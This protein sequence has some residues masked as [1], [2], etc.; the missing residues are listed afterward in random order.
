MKMSLPTP[1]IGANMSPKQLEA[2]EAPLIAL[3]NSAG[4]DL[5][6]LMY[7]FFSFLHRRT[8]FYLVPNDADIKEGKS[9]MGFLEGEAEKLLLAAFRQFPLRRMPRQQQQHVTDKPAQEDEP[10]PFLGKKQVPPPALKDKEKDT[11]TSVAPDKKFATKKAEDET[12]LYTEEGLQVPVGNG[13]STKRFKWTQTIDECTVL[14]G[15]PEGIRAKELDVSIKASSI[16]A[17]TKSKNADGEV[18]V[19]VEGALVEKVKPDECTWSLEGG[20]LLLILYKVKKTF[21]A[22]IIEG[23]EKIDTSQV[24]SR[25]HISE[26]DEATQGQLR[27]IMFDQKQQEK[28]LPSSDE[29]IG[30]RTIPPMPPGVEYIDSEKLNEADKQRQKQKL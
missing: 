8:D 13:G 19:F 3:A 4:G 23:D 2:M 29:L 9:K 12:I 30:K 16:H 7:G 11:A 5:R 21:W 25:R 24:D 17:K 22:T 20:V 28:G 18:T 15:L 26:Y 10:V 1:T 27:K 6:M 14:V